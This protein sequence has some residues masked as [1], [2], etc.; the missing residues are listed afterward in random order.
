MNWAANNI[1]HLRK[2][3]KSWAASATNK[4]ADT[5]IRALLTQGLSVKFSDIPKSLVDLKREQL[6]LKRSIK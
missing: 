1:G 2:Y 3:K 4:L 6:R 5:Y